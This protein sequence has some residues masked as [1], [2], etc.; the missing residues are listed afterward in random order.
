MAL[1]PSQE[2]GFPGVQTPPLQRSPVEPALASVS[3]DP[4]ALPVS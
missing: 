3:G 1:I 2:M 4:K